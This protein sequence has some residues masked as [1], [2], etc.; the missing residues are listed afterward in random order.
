[1]CS[2]EGPRHSHVD[3][4]EPRNQPG[5]QDGTRVAAQFGALAAEV[6]HLPGEAALDPDAQAVEAVGRRRRR[7]A[8]AREAEPACLLDQASFQFSD[9]VS[10]SALGV[11]I[12]SAAILLRSGFL[13]CSLPDARLASSQKVRAV[14]NHRTPNS[15]TQGKQGKCRHT[16]KT[17]HKA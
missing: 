6:A 13:A 12:L 4:H 7:D 17:S 5:R 14:K 3:L 1:M 2:D 16:P 10:P 9:L 15:H 8:A 11:T